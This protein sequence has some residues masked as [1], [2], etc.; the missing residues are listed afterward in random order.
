MI[1]ISK[2]HIIKH[3]I[4]SLKVPLSK[5]DIFL[6][7][8]GINIC[9]VSRQYFLSKRAIKDLYWMGLSDL[10]TEGQWIWVDSTP[11]NETGA[12]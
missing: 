6:N 5:F 2:Y 7:M 4:I 8:L 3:F 10:E 9:D 1:N 12:V 11:L